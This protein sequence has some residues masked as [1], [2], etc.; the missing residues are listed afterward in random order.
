MFY[1][2]PVPAWTVK[3]KE[4][5]TVPDH[6]RG[7]IDQVRGR[8]QSRRELDDSS[9]ALSRWGTMLGFIHFE[10]TTYGRDL[11]IAPYRS[12]SYNPHQGTIRLILR[13]INLVFPIKRVS[14]VSR[15]QSTDIKGYFPIQ[16]SY[17]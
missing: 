8:H 4:G 1:L 11:Y 16:A 10:K 13:S 14:P 7:I 2:G 17:R 6:E 15:A 12:V 9:N 3:R 5:A